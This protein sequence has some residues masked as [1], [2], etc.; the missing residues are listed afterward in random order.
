MNLPLNT[1]R[2]QFN[3]DFTFKDLKDI[4]PYLKKLGVDCIYASPIFKAVPG[5]T[6]GYDITD[7]HQINPEIGIYSELRNIKDE[8]R[9]NNIKWVQDIVPNHMAF[10]PENFW[11]MDILEKKKESEFYNFFDIYWN[12]PNYKGK[13]MVPILGEPLD[14]AIENNKI[15]L[16][17][18]DEGIHI[19]YYD[20]SF[21]AA[22]TSYKY[23]LDAASVYKKRVLSIINRDEEIQENLNQ[24]IENKKM[25][26]EFLDLQNF[27]LVPWQET[28]HSINYR[29]FFTING[30]ISLK[31]E[32]EYVFN[33][34][35]KFI[36]K[37]I[38]E[39]IFD[40]LRIDHI[41]GLLDPTSYLKRLRT[42]I[43]KNIP[44]Y[45]EKI[46]EPD[47]MLPH[48]WVC[49]GTTGYDFLANVNRLLTQSNG[50][51]TL[52]E[53]YSENI[54]TQEDYKNIVFINKKKFLTQYMEGE[55]NNVY[56]MLKELFPGYDKVT[57]SV[58]LA[59]M[60]VYRIY[61][62]EKGLSPA[63]KKILFH[64]AEN[65]NYY[66]GDNNALNL[67]KEL[68]EGN[69]DQ[70]LYFMQRFQQLSGP[71]AAKGIE[72]TTFYHYNSFISHNEVGDNPDFSDYGKTSF[73]TYIQVRNIN[74]K[75]SINAT[76]THDTKRG[77]DARMRINVLREIPEQWKEFVLKL[78][79]YVK[80]LN[81]KAIPDVNDQYFLYQTLLG[82]LPANL[83]I[84]DDYIKRLQEY[85]IKV[86]REGKI[87][88]DWSKPNEL[89]E[90]NL[91][92]FINVILKDEEVLNNIKEIHSTCT[93]YGALNSLSQLILKYTLP[94]V[95]DTYQGS[96][97]WN[98]SFVD[99][100]NRRPVDF[101]KRNNLL[102]NCIH[103]NLT[104]IHDKFHKNP[105]DP[106]V[107]LYF[108]NR[109]MELRIEY[110][111][112]FLNGS[113]KTL[114]VNGIKA[115][116][117]YAF[118]RSFEDQQAIVMCG[119][120]FKTFYPEN[121]LEGNGWEETLILLDSP[122]EYKN[123]LS[124]EFIKMNKDVSL[125]DVFKL[126]PVAVLIKM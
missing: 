74:N 58:L 52:G 109:L 82:S 13:L 54:S 76:S 2:I 24:F 79:S 80:E 27:Q 100:D 38:K 64:A 48:H 119:R 19:D 15:K 107:K 37:C 115:D 126:F 17:L 123:V 111:D 40:G 22:I 23:I 65:A 5:S 103:Y 77:E 114:D 12:H 113:F 7:P 95:A 120:L 56:L 89:Y 121:K 101:E 92:S 31:M 14:V 61:P 68:S 117:V 86:V 60:P 73:T 3:K 122:G 88:S 106:E 44:I 42:A 102:S 34:Y 71:L 105:N 39:E 118:T 97:L 93:F 87:N 62:D 78:F 16:S 33:H 85:M 25:L 57:L 9:Q 124:D 99:P 104:Q 45:V 67:A 110:P 4:I 72:D 55:L 116:H 69:G 91:N 98:F 108:T 30:L 46:L 75:Y 81:I 26:R 32:E 96:E 11:L 50:A 6:H 43:G 41:D 49:E 83:N 84:N 59:G 8:L 28:D 51:N 10:H 53:I 63:D 35:H 20:Q 21:P 70:W 125:K 47:E 112:L 94:G 36:F 66:N 1:Y 18:K 29:R 90:N